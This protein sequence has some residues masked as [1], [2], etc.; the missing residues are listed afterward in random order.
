MNIILINLIRVFN[1]TFYFLKKMKFKNLF[2][3]IIN[4]KEIMFYH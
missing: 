3:K 4:H 2:I 1:I